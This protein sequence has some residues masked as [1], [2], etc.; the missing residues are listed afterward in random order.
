MS[1]S[2]ASPLLPPVVPFPQFARHENGW[3][4]HYGA[5]RV[6][7]AYAGATLPPFYHLRAVWQHGVF[8]PWQHYDPRVLIYQTPEARRLPL[9]VARRDEAD[10]LR[11]EG[12]PLARAIGMPIA[13]T[14]P[15]GLA[16]TPRSLLVVPTHSLAGYTFPDRTPFERYADEVVAAA[17]D[18]EKVTV[19]IHPNCRQNGLWVKEFQSRG[20]E[21]VYG[22]QTNDANALLRMRSLFE[23]FE[24]VTTNDWGSHVA[25]A[26][27]FGARVSI[28]GLRVAPELSVYLNDACWAAN[29]EA[30]KRAFSPEILAAQ[31]SY[32]ERFYVAPRDGIADPDFGRRLIGADLLLKPEEMAD[33]LAEMIDPAAFTANPAPRRPRLLWVT[34]AGP[35]EGPDAFS[36]N[37]LRR[38]RRDTRQNFEIVATSHDVAG[39]TEL[40][41]VAVI[42]PGEL[43]RESDYLRQ[44][45]LIV[46]NTCQPGPLFPDLARS[47]RPVVTLLQETDLTHNGWTARG[48]AAV[49]AHSSAL[50]ARD[51]VQAEEFRRRFGIPAGRLTIAGAGSPD[52]PL[53]GD[54]LWH[55]LSA[56]LGSARPAGAKPNVVSPAEIYSQ[57]SSE[58]TPDPSYV[59][60]HLARHRVRRESRELISAGRKAEAVR[61]LCQAVR[62]DLGS[63]NPLIIFE[64]LVQIGDELAALEPRQSAHLLGEAEKIS[65]QA[66]QFQISAFR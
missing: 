40:S 32:L 63:K 46:V 37:F 30:L 3:S 56:F 13:Y 2:G 14:A 61:A 18:F 17:A 51:A 52:A 11:R 10:Y 7:A 43:T 60:A 6:A 26:L 44:F 66:P 55:F 47:G 54:A 36:L 62:S 24:S 41:R 65:K 15:S 59:A 33:V 31:R 19:C 22:A 48:M 12:Y 49:L 64:S 50:V 5:L 53:G 21:I 45:D 4:D 29:P 8:G 58:G 57:W 16:R 20:F 38:L 27:A 1:L 42:Y 34:P 23:Q 28:A 9:Y 39:E 35:V 25:Y